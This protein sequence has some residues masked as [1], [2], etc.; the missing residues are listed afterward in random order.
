MNDLKTF[1][2]R[3]VGDESRD[4]LADVL[5]SVFPGAQVYAVNDNFV[6]FLNTL[7]VWC[8]RTAIRNHRHLLEQIRDT[9]SENT[10]EWTRFGYVIA[11]DGTWPYTNV[12][13]IEMN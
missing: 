9:P 3:P 13:Q 1:H 11:V 12:V 4:H 5:R 8:T 2:S 10:R 6:A 7:E